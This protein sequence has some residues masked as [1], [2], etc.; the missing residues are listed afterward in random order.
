MT[1]KDIL[2]N[3]RA[4]FER[5]PRMHAHQNHIRLDLR[6]GVLILEGEVDEIAAKKLAVEL[7]GAFAVNGIEDRLRLVSA[8]P[9]ED[10]EIRDAVLDALTDEPTL[11]NCAL[12]AW[13]KDK[14]E[15]IREAQ[16]ESDGGAIHVFVEDG[17]VTLEGRVLSLSHQRLAGVLAWWVPGCRDVD[18]KLAVNPPEE[19]NDDEINDAVN[20]VLEKDHTLPA[21]QIHI[22][23]KDRVVTLEGLVFQEAEK[24]M[25][26]TDTWYVQR[27][28]NVINKIEVRH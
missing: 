13:I 5:E 22:T 21:G 11:K 19:D 28:R 20:L 6:N 7:A 24:K 26:E 27:V 2:K 4:A 25:A 1:D 10:G 18:N 17:I 3:I 12:R 8:E 15:I 23:T 14:E 9:V 16:P